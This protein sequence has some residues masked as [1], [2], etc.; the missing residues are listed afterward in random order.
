MIKYRRK[1]LC[2]NPW[3]H[4]NLKKINASYQ[5]GLFLKVSGF[6]LLII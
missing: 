3:D 4:Q 5:T 1:M 6:N 2:F